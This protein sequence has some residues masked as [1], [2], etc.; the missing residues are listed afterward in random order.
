MIKAGEDPF[1]LGRRRDIW[2][3]CHSMKYACRKLHGGIQ[4]SGGQTCA[5]YP[6]WMMDGGQNG[7]GALT[8][9]KDH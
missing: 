3:Q 9:S 6:S 7:Y 1:E 4:G 8:N 2:L 5:E